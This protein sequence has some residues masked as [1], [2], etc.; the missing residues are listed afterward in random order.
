MI[1]VL[2]A[3]LA[4]LAQQT[5]IP[6]TLGVATIEAGGACPDVPVGVAPGVVRTNLGVMLLADDGTY[7]YGCPSRWGGDDDAQVAARPDRSEILVLGDAG[8]FRSTDGG[9]SFQSLAL[10]E[11]TVGRQLLWWRD[12]FYLLTNAEVGDGGALMQVGERDFVPLATWT[13]F[14]PDGAAPG[15]ADKIWLSGARPQPQVRRLTVVGG[16]GGD[17]PLPDLPSDYAGVV[18]IE[19]RAADEDEAWFAV[20][21]TTSQW[22]WHAAT[23]DVDGVQSQV[24]SEV[25]PRARSIA[26]PIK[27]GNRW[28]AVIDGELNLAPELENAWTPTGTQVSWTCLQQLGDHVFACDIHD[29][30]EVHGIGK[31]GKPNTTPIFSWLQVGPPSPTCSDAACDADWQRAGDAA[32]L[33]DAEAPAVC[34]DGRTQADLD[35]KECTC[36]QGDAG[37]LGAVALLALAGL[38]RRHSPRPRSR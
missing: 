5:P 8:L 27:V 24:F 19:P 2:L 18:A 10:P 11:G 33:L 25:E 37:G 1:F 31:A 32:G 35:F 13:D 4:A 17:E 15:G 7:V 28:A 29:V 6:V 20:R 14:T 30:V 22:T 9:C 3:T 36:A 34:P 23:Y 16:V 12:G 38:R 26:G 21:R